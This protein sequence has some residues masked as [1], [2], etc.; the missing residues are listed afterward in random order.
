MNDEQRQEIIRRLQQG[1][2]LQPEWRW[3]LFPPEKQECELVYGGKQREEDILAHTMAV[4]LQNVRTFNNGNGRPTPGQWYNRLISGDN[5]QAMKSLLDDPD[6]KGKVKLVYIDP[7]FA[8]KQDFQ[9]SQDQKA[10]QDK[11]EGAEFIEF[12]RKRLV[13]LKA[14]LANDGSIFVH[15]DQR[16]IHY[17]KVILDELFQEHNFRNEIM[18]PGRASKNLQQQFETIS[19]LNV[20]HDSL[21]WYSSSSST[22]FSPVWI[23]KHSRGNPEGHWHHFWSTADRGTMR[24]KLFGITPQT[25]QWT[26][27]EERALQ[28]VAN[29]K[30]FEKESGGRTLAE[31]WRDTGCALEFIRPDPDDGKPQYWRAPAENRLADTAWAGIPIYS[32]S[33]KYPTE[34]NEALLAQIIDLAS[35]KNELVMDVFAGSGTTCA[36]AEKLGRRWIGIDCGKL[37]QYTIQ[38][39]MLNLREEIGNKGKSLTAKPFLVQNAGL[40]DF[41]SLRDLPWEDWRFFALQLF[42]CKDHQHKIGGL[43]LDG[44]KAGAPVLVFD[45][46]KNPNE[47]ISEETIADIHGMVGRKI[48]KKFYIIAPMMA[49]DFFQDYVDCGNVRY[50]AL[51]IPYTMIQELHKRDFKSVLQARDEGNV[52]DIQEAYGFSFMIAPEVEWKAKVE[53]QKDDLFSSALLETKKFVSKARIKGTEREGGMETLAMLMVDLNY[54]GKVF[55]LD[56]ALYGEQLEKA[57]W[58]MRFSTEEVGEKVMAVWID[59]HG[60]EAKVVIAREDFGLPKLKPTPTPSKNAPETKTKA[61]VKTKSA[62]K[63]SK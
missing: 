31:Y 6:V 5:L 42:E 47:K 16:K 49:F 12:L 28:A 43:T 15:M 9:G 52:N 19:R 21:L 20:R 11:V 39:R 32:N 13:L 7:P 59:Y 41:E 35:D 37:A 40:Y 62:T 56:T 24:Y 4:P 38:K 29:Y 22:R 57:K 58:T 34:K 53:K 8:S 25:G 10:Y 36:V 2:N 1:E 60:N 51:R 63:R 54:D 23:E 33:T 14:L 50:Y 18:L 17:V 26:W 27:K 30:R 3:T 55:D 46:K 44:E 45:W 61:K 48:G